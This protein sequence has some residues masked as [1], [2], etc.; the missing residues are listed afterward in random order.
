MWPPRRALTA[1]TPLGVALAVAGCGGG[2][3]AKKAAPAQPSATGPGGRLTLRADP[4][5]QLKF[6]RKTLSAKAGKVTI[7][8]NNPAPLSH[9][10]SLE[11]AG[12]SQEG[13]TVGQGGTSTVSATLKPGRYTF[14]CSV[15]GHREAGMVGTLTVQ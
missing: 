6:N 11:G 5:G 9:N 4:G 1:L 10:V 15:P 3:G 14:F 8:M 12:I 7:V 13:E 2:G